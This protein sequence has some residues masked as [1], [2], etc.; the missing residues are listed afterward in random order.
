MGQHRAVQHAPISQSISCISAMAA[1]QKHSSPAVKYRTG[2]GPWTNGSAPLRGAQLFPWSSGWAHCSLEPCRK[3]SHWFLMQKSA[4]VVF[5]SGWAGCTARLRGYLPSLSWQPGSCYNIKHNTSYGLT[6]EFLSC[7]LVLKH[8]SFRHL[9]QVLLIRLRKLSLQKDQQL[10]WGKW[11][12]PT[13]RAENKRRNFS[14]ITH[15]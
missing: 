6:L 2:N 8:Y 5:G 3:H 15:L 14:I 12:G 9:V 13:L 10:K 1:R 11:G 4:A 7:V